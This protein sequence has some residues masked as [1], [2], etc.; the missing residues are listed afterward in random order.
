[1]RWIGQEEGTWP[2]SNVHESFSI[3][4]GVSR[5]VLLFK[6]GIPLLQASSRIL[7]PQLVIND[8]EVE[9]LLKPNTDSMIFEG[10]VGS[11]GISITTVVCVLCSMVKGGW[12]NCTFLDA[13]FTI[14]GR[15]AVS[16][17][18][19]VSVI[20][21]ANWVYT[22]G[23]IMLVCHFDWVMDICRLF[24]VAI[25]MPD[26][27]AEEKAKALLC[28]GAKVKKVR[29]A[30]I[31]DKKQVREQIAFIAFSLLNRDSLWYGPPA[32]TSSILSR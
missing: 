6:V 28:L 20:F 18:V 4:G 5:I 2:F 23:V 1:V 11:T 21:R 19:K 27:I 29:P 7:N 22:K 3:Q 12:S 9:G 24:V 26:D 10:T 25:I 17:L 13:G 31:V 15:C 8:A 14:L 32:S 16:T 30:S